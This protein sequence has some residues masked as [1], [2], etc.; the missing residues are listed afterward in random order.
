VHQHLKNMP[1]TDNKN[2]D[3]ASIGVP[4]DETDIPIL[5][6][7]ETE[8]PSNGSGD[9]LLIRE[10]TFTP[11]L[12]KLVNKVTGQSPDRTKERAFNDAEMAPV[13]PDITDEELLKKY[14]RLFYRTLHFK[15]RAHAS[16]GYFLSTGNVSFDDSSLNQII[17]D[18]LSKI[19]SNGF[20]L[21]SYSISQKSYIPFTNTITDIDIFK[22][23]ISLNDDICRL[24]QRSVDGIIISSDDVVR[25]PLL[26]KYFRQLHLPQ[27]TRIYLN[28]YHNFYI[29]LPDSLTVFSPRPLFNTASPLMIVKVRIEDSAHDVYTMIKSTISSCLLFYAANQI[30]LFQETGTGNFENLFRVLEL[31]YTIFHSKKSGIIL[32]ITV[33]IKAS[34]EYRYILSYL[35]LKLESHLSGS[36]MVYQPDRDML[37]IFSATDD[38]QPVERLL[39]E[40]NQSTDGCLHVQNLEYSGETGFIQFLERYVF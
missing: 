19:S 14:H 5:S 39:N 27:N 12:R 34:L 15:D 8:T 10:R 13:G 30:R 26:K 3:N 24:I 35:M 25:D 33:D 37:L 11:D 22:I 23:F 28:F 2:M 29:D 16:G 17:T 32:K 21:L 1:E 4:F 38:V 36:S 7:G 18:E 6:E 40:Y 20:A 9:V 31:Y